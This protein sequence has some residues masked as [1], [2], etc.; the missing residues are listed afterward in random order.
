MAKMQWVQIEIEE[1]LFKCKRKPQNHFSTMRV[2]RHW[3]RLPR[4]IMESL[5]MQML[6]IQ[7]LM[8][9]SNLLLLTLL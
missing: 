5:S 6:Q 2:V 8:A 7:V 4:E 9:V 3:H 1:T